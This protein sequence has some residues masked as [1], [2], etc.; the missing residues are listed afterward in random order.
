MGV[1]A[2]VVAAAGA[3]VVAAGDVV[4]TEDDDEAEPPAFWTFAVVPVSQTVQNPSP[5]PK[6]ENVSVTNGGRSSE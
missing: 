4:A 1:P 3:D 5:P 6:F 2:V